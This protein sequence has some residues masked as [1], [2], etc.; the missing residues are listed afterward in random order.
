MLSWGDALIK[1]DC[2]TVE[3][4]DSDQGCP[5][6]TYGEGQPWSWTWATPSCSSSCGRA[7]GTVLVLGVLVQEDQSEVGGNN[8]C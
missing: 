2:K 4:H 5:V 6:E 8:A 7:E 1:K 3:A